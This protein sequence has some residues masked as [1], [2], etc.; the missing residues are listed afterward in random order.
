[1][2]T[3]YTAPGPCVFNAARDFSLNINDDS[4]PWSYRLDLQADTS[5]R[6]AAPPLL[7]AFGDVLGGWV[8]NWTPGPPLLGWHDGDP[9]RNKAGFTVNNTGFAQSGWGGAVIVPDERILIGPLVVDEKGMLVLSWLAPAAGPYVVDYSF[10]KA[11]DGGDGLNWFIDLNGSDGT[12]LAAGSLSSSLG[13]TDADTLFVQVAAGDRINFVFD[14]GASG[15]Y[16]L[17]HFNVVTRLVP[18]PSTLV[19]LAFGALGLVLLRRRK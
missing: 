14:A 15:A 8:P 1:M 6:L 12:S 13:D 11:Q 4:M 17:M 16:D 10:T 5:T 3:A 2:D 19:L 9:T 18:E 7:P